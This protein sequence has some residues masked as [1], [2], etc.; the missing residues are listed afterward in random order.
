MENYNNNQQQNNNQIVPQNQENEGFDI[1]LM[2]IWKFFTGN[3]FWFLISIVICLGAGVLY[4]KVSPKIYSSS[5]LIYIDEN[6]SRSVKSDVT[7]MTNFRMMRQTSVVDN[8]AAILRSLTLMERVV[9]NLDLN[10]VYKKPAKLRKVEVYAP[11]VPAF[12]EVDSLMRGFVME[13]NLTQ[14]DAS[15]VIKYTLPGGDK[16]EM[17]FSSEYDKPIY[18]EMGIVRIVKNDLYQEDYAAAIDKN[19]KFEVSVASVRAA[20]RSYA[21]ALSVAPSSKTTSLISVGIKTPVAQ[22]S[23]DIVNELIYVYNEDAK[24]GERAVARA[25][26]EFVDERLAIVG[27]DLEEVDSDVANYRKSAKSVNPTSESELYVQA[28]SKLESE[29]VEIETQISILKDVLASVKAVSGSVELVP[30]LGISDTSLNAIISDYNNSVLQY[31]MMGGDD[32]LSNPSVRN[33]KERVLSMQELLPASIK[34]LQ[35]SLEVKLRSVNRQIAENEARVSNLPSVEK[36]AQSIL[37]NQQIKVRIYEYLLNKREETS[38]KLATTAPVSRVIDPALPAILPVSPR[39]IMIML[40]ALILGFVIPVVIIF[41]AEAL[42]TKI[43][44]V[45]EVESA[46][47]TDVPIV[48]AI[49]S[50]EARHTSDI[51]VTPNSRDAIAEA[52]RMVRTNIDFMMPKGGK[53]IMTTSTVPSEGKTTMALNIA[54]SFVITGKKVVIVDMDMRKGSME[55]RVGVKHQSKGIVT[56][57]MGHETNVENLIVK[58]CVHGVDAL[59]VGTIPP[60]PAELLMRPEIDAMFDELKKIYDYI[61]VDTAPIALVTDTQ[62][63]NRLADITLYCMR[64]GHTEKVSLDTVKAISMRKSLNN[65]GVLISQVGV[66]KLYYG[67]EK[68]STNFGYGYGYGYGYVASGKKE[69]AFKRAISYLKRKKK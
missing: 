25:T 5:A 4:C 66:G 37:R 36:G 40:L 26:M 54:L 64:M 41:V 13:L 10:V 47:G 22:K 16:R 24:E 57:L 19:D 51:M 55:K 52:F 42:R 7:S 61:I 58:D 31:R 35:S 43:Y 14:N 8:E 20:A 1:S 29:A 46:I 62:I 39:T 12:V 49:P 63:I 30:N 53:V 2:S 9:E 44:S 28:A 59:F 68:R 38:L 17:K 34:N 65:L 48:G 6:A 23:A 56:Y 69:S 60:N 3:W 15:G 27:G 50:K 21:S 33:M 67:G 45:E 18:G 11:T 32:K